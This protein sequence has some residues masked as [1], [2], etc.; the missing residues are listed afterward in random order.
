MQ[1]AQTGLAVNAEALGVA[2]RL[3]E[4]N[5]AKRARRQSDLEQGED[6]AVVMLGPS[7]A[8]YAVHADGSPP[9]VAA[10]AV[11]ARILAT[12]AEVS[13]WPT[14]PAEGAAFADKLVAFG[15]SCRSFK[16]GGRGFD[17]GLGA[18]SYKVRSFTRA[19][20]LQVIIYMMYVV[21]CFSNRRT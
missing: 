12:A 10:V 1:S 13:A 5:V 4:W 6:A 14:D 9:F 7:Q 18:H 8:V 11:V 17:G 16:S 21:I 3:D 19:M 2:T 15:R 20:L